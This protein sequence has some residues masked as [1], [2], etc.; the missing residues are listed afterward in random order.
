V[1][2][3]AGVWLKTARYA[4]GVVT[5]DYDN[6]G[7]QDIYVANDSVL[8]S[9]WRNRGDGTFEDVGLTS[10][11]ALNSTG[12]PQGCMGTNFGDYNGDGWFDLVVTNFS[13]DVNTIYRSVSGKFFVDES[14]TIGMATTA[15]ELSWGTAFHDFDNDSDVDLFIANGHVYTDMDE[16]GIGSTYYQPNHVFVNEQ[17]KFRK[18]ESAGTL[19]ARSWRGTAFG[20]YDEDGDIDMFVTAM[21]APGMLLRNDT[22]ESGHYLQLALEGT[23]SNRDAVGTRVIVTA[24]GRKQIGERFGGGSYL[25]A[26]DPKLHF[27]LGRAKRVE[28]V[29]IRWPSGRREILENVEVDQV[30]VVREAAP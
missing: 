3:S 18:V 8:N 25:S 12:S 20:D 5:V 2:Q 27:G 11:S 23:A 13:H 14:V 26:S 28:R 24:A 4:M 10:L 30:L 21:D 22:P 19:I 29:E 1:T 7:D 15:M 16:E 17:G 6:D 9:L